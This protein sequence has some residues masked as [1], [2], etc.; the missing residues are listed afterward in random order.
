LDGSVSEIGYIP[1][2][3]PD[4]GVGSDC[5]SGT[6]ENLESLYKKDPVAVTGLPQNVHQVCAAEDFGVA[7]TDDGKVWVWGHMG[8]TNGVSPR[9]IPSLRNIVKIAVN[10]SYCLLALDKNGVVWGWGYNGWDYTALLGI[11]APD[12]END[13]YSTAIRI[14]GIENV[15]D[16]F[17]GDTDAFALGTE[18]EGKPVGLIARSSDQA[19]LLSWSN[20]VAA[21]SYVIYRS[22]NE[23]AGYVSIGNS[24]L[25][26]YADENPPLKNG[27]TYYYKVSAVVNGVETTSSWD[28]SATP[29]PPPTSVTSLTASWA[30]S[31]VTLQ[32]QAPTNVVASPVDNY[33][34]MLGNLNLAEL[35]PG[36]TNYYDDTTVVRSTNYIYTVIAVNSSGQTSNSIVLYSN[37]PSIDC[38]PAPFVA[39][40]LNSSWLSVA[41]NNNCGSDTATLVWTGTTN[42]VWLFRMTEFDTYLGDDNISGTETVSGF[43][44]ILANADSVFDPL[45]AWLWSQFIINGVDTNTL[46]DTD[47]P[48]SSK[49]GILVPA[50]NQILTNG[51]PV[52]NLEFF[53]S[54]VQDNYYGDGCIN[55]E[56]RMASTTLFNTAPQ[57]AD[58]MQLKRMLLDDCF[59]GRFFTRGGNWGGN[60]TGFRIHY[61]T[62]QYVN[63]RKIEQDLKQDVNVSSLKYG[64]SSGYNDNE[65]VRCGVYQYSW[66]IPQGVLCWA[67]VSA[68]V[69]GHESEISV[70]VGP[71][72]ANSYTGEYLNYALRAIPGN[73]QIYLDWV[74]DPDAISYNVFYSTNSDDTNSWNLYPG[75]GTWQ[76]VP[77]GIDLSINRC[78]HTNL[79]VGKTYY[80]IVQ[81]NDYFCGYWNPHIFAF[82]MVTDST[83]ETNQFSAFA[84]AYDSMVEV[85]WTVPTNQYTFTDTSVNQ[86]NWQFFVERK[87]AS[88]NDSQYIL[89]ADSGYGLAYLDSDVA[90]GQAY[91]YRVTAFDTDFNRLQALAV[92]KADGTSIQITPSATN[93]L[94]LLQPKSGNSYVDL[95][96]SP[97][98][99]TQ[100]SIKRS[101]N[102][103]GPFDVVGSLNVN[104]A[105]QSAANTYRDT[106]LQNGVMY[107]YQIAAIT[108]T[109][110]E[111]D[112]SVQGAVPLATLTPLP[113][114]GFQGTIVPISDAAQA[115]FTNIVLLSWNAEPGVSQYQVFLQ[116]QTS[117]TPLFTGRGTSCT[118]V[119]PDAEQNNPNAAFTFALR[120][121]NA[122]GLTSDLVEIAVTNQ[123]IT[124]FTGTVNPVVLQIAG[125]LNSLVVTGPTNLT[126]NAAVNVPGI[127]QV[128]FYSDGQ[129][130]GTVASAP[131]QMTWYHVPGTSPGSF[132]IV[133]AVAQASSSGSAGAYLGYGSGSVASFISGRFILTNNVEP[134]L[135]AYQTSV[136]DLQLPAPA[137]PISL[138]RS[139]TS[140][141]TDTNGTLGVGWTPSWNLGSVKLSADLG[142]GWTALD[143]TASWSS[144]EE[145]FI[146]ENTAQNTAHIVTMTLPSGQSTSFGVHLD[147][148]PSVSPDYDANPVETI[149]MDFQDY[150]ANPG[151]L[152]SSTIGVS[153]NCDN[154]VNNWPDADA[155]SGDVGLTVPTLSQFTYVG[156]DGTTNV[157]GQHGSDNLT[158]LLTKTT[159]RNGNSLVYTY[160]SDKSLQSIANSCGRS[161]SFRYVTPPTTPTGVTNIEIYD[162]LSPLGAGAPAFA[163]V[164]VYVVSNNFLTQVRQLTARTNYNNGIYLT[165]SYTY[166][167][168]PTDTNNFN[169]LTGVYDARG[170]LVLKNNYTNGTGDLAVQISPG[171][172]NTFQVD[173]DYDLTVTTTS[174]TATNTAKVTSDSSG[175]IS[176]ATVPVSG[177]SASSTKATQCSYDSNGNLISQTDANGNVKTYSYD[178]TNRLVGQS[179]ENGNSTAVALNNYSQPTISTDA[180]G[181]QTLYEYDNNGNTLNVRDP[182]GT[183]TAYTYATVTDGN[184][185]ASGLQ[186]NVSQN[187]PFVPYTIVTANLYDS[188][189]NLTNTIEK[190]TDGGGNPVGAQVSTSY[191][192]DA[193]GN[194][195]TEIKQRTL[196][197]GGTQYITNAYT[198]DAQNRVVQTVV[199][200]G[201]AEVLVPQTNTVSYNLLGKQAMSTDAAGRVTTNVYD[202]N[203]NLIETD[204]PDG[205]VS[206]TSYDGFGRQDFVQER[207]VPSGGATTAPATRNTY[208]A[209]GRVIK[210]E[211]FAS[212]T[213]AKANASAPGDFAGTPVE[214]QYKMVYS[215]LGTVLTTTRTFY[216]AVGRVQYSVDAR[217]A[218]TQYQYDAAGRRTDMLVYAIGYSPTND[219]PPNPGSLGTVQSTSYVYDAN[220]NQTTVTDAAGHTITSVYD[221]AN[222]V[223]EMDY[224]AGSGNGTVG[225]YTYYDGLGRKIQETDEAGVSTAYTYDF[226]GLLTSVTLAFG[227]AQSV[228]TVYAY[229]E[230]G[231][232]IRQTDAAGHSTT[233]QYDAL[234]RRT[235][236]LLPGGQSEGY[237]Y[238]NV[239]NTGN[240]RYQT[241]FNGVVITNL[242]DFASS[243]LTNCS[244]VGYKTTY[245]YTQTGLRTNMVD[246]SGVTTYY[247]NG[248]SQL[249]NK[250][251]TWSGQSPVS[252]NYRY[253]PL[254]SLTNLWSSTAN[255]VSNAFQ[256]DLLGRLTNVLANGS[257][258]ASY[259]YDLVGNLQSQCYGNGVTNL[260]QYDARNRLTNQVWK[261]GGATLAG[262]GYTLGATGNRTALVETVNGTARTC[263]WAYDYLYRLTGETLGNMGTVNYGF[264]AVGN[265][266][267]RTGVSGISS[268]TAS[269]TANDWLASDAYDANGNTTNSGPANYQ[270]DALNHLTNA[271]HGAVLLTYDGD[272]NRVS[273]TVGGVTT[274]Y[275][276]DDRNP[277]GYAQVLEE[278]QGTNLSRVYNYGLALISERQAG[279]G[280]VSY[281]GTDGHG[282]TRFLTNPNGAA[283]DSYVYDAYGILISGSGSTPNNYLYC[284][285]QWDGDLGMYYLRARYYQPDTGRFWTMDTFEGNNEDPLSLHKYLYAQDDP[286]DNVDPL[287]QWASTPSFPVHQAAIDAVLNFLPDIDREYLRDAQ[288]LVDEHQDA[289]ESYMHAMRDG[290]H[291]QT[292]PQAKAL[293]NAFVKR[294][295][296]EARRYQQRGYHGKAMKE[297]GQA[298]HTLQDSTSPMHHGFQPW[299]NY[300]GGAFNPNEI[301]HGMGE[302]LNPGPGSWLY[303]ATRQAYDYF[304]GTPFPGDFFQNLGG[305]QNSVIMLLNKANQKARSAVSAIS[306]QDF[307]IGF[308]LGDGL[309]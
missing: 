202:F 300:F 199:S 30:C 108:P 216:D 159:D 128:S 41:G 246:A 160:N 173:A 16:I 26:S 66:P 294:H 288:E 307:T 101:L 15:T 131:Y 69:D 35:S 44:D 50:L 214:P 277:S 204:Y 137:L 46:R 176:G 105:Y 36:V 92:S 126:L 242:Y 292:V 9:Q 230:L 14:P 272:G 303:K 124:T 22:L 91:T 54:A 308:N 13:F 186:S 296:S 309:F 299:Y 111:I 223:K 244:S 222:R 49:L 291:G 138:S 123:N 141:S 255:G 45:P 276:V 180:N 168:N 125:A 8:D 31:G 27:Q 227:T 262:F 148:N 10:Y 266:T 198:Y 275:L 134:Q 208:D 306:I 106:G 129:L 284:G 301:A 232:L 81:V 82:A 52:N 172:T 287:G 42:G 261:A 60:L 256:Y 59:G 281:Y 249:T 93:G 231:N 240:L 200:A 89:I 152:S 290:D 58:L 233:N 188:S 267:N 157:F 279:S 283:T 155:W 203:G 257:S 184:V 221:D 293:S 196:S 5:G 7:L 241:N 269:Y 38:K 210:V 97:I 298:M 285:Q 18:V 170:I 181:K 112:S 19:V 73:H 189:G 142:S 237:C 103:G 195:L 209:S 167:T 260:C 207:A 147:Y 77:E 143:Q 191:A 67:S 84:S 90:D 201:G 34:V 6:L 74:D 254:G 286:V 32:W 146:T 99:A 75:A 175:A 62:L 24:T 228:T 161:V 39:T 165:T 169:R 80:Y 182:S 274:C 185:L 162:S 109:G 193:N 86:T 85:E 171:R 70:E 71:Q 278:Y 252:L 235:A 194:R 28:V 153:V 64:L 122:Q 21:S 107:Y 282:S 20:Y 100:F 177:T 229:D 4:A 297:L 72:T 29:F 56:L 3:D 121:V 127:S 149:S 166:S 197:S 302:A 187:A 158:W 113:P 145:Y 304:N 305:D 135:S 215:A 83:S 248:L 2:L 68:L 96:W 253:D 265:R 1:S 94:T 273:K 250:T 174:S 150:S 43:V 88:T 280:M 23:D 17:C 76:P 251:V 139:Y 213:L 79:D 238:D 33:V 190:W 258:A 120:S 259:G 98:R 163:P 116:N 110:F 136:T 40:N 117:L 51:Q 47:A 104:N 87:P 263:N 183:V 219:T 78:W 220:G 218:V 151:L 211:K 63:G 239:Y 61:Q 154:W 295:L 192:Y 268:Q 118:Y 144:S 140:R 53:V 119:I 271:N 65:G 133:T 224:P 114:S 156:P 55:G 205:T 289:S 25:N 178:A 48:V 217:G 206:R 37:G 226:R 270:Y 225:R 247:Y 164:V 212:V 95:S 11:P 132:H 115:Q 12:H 264:D 102:P 179:D 245:A 130:I 243:R 234:G 57:G 236:R